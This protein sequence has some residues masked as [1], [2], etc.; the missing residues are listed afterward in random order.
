MVSGV[1]GQGY[2]IV[3]QGIVYGGRQLV[4][5]IVF[6][7]RSIVIDGTVYEGTHCTHNGY[8]YDG[9]YIGGFP[10]VFGYPVGHGVYNGHNV[11]SDGIIFNG[12]NLV[13]GGTSYGAHGVS[14]GGYLYDGY[15]VDGVN[16]VYGHPGNYFGRSHVISKRNVDHYCH[17]NCHHNYDPVC[18]TDGN[19]YSNLCEL[20]KEQC[21]T[22]NWNLVVEYH[23]VCRT[24]LHCTGG[25]VYNECGSA[26]PRSCGNLNPIC[27][28][29]CVERCSCPAGQVFED[30]N[31][32]NCI[33]EN[34]CPTG[35]C[36]E[37]CHYNYDPVCGTDG[38]TYSNQCE[39]EKKQCETGNW[40]LV[41]EYHG[42][43]RTSRCP[44]F[45]HYNYDP[46]CGTDG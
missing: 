40:N 6:N 45:C 25:T 22:G 30:K 34:Y 2:G 39:L 29:E 15:P 10:T 7:G 12:Q 27:T 3:G 23:G 11:F 9:R 19:T 4:N 44:K 36:P 24:S 26:C 46:V 41:V 35:R 38:N 37:F 33:P 18:G 32:I 43:C 14:Y 17:Y 16:V 1:L 20:E 13:I 31:Y 21:E 8:V 5:S 28:L 42:V